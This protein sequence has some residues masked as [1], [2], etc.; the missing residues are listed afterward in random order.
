MTL[1]MLFGSRSKKRYLI[2]PLLPK[3]HALGPLSATL[4]KKQPRHPSDCHQLLDSLRV[5]ALN[6]P[7]TSWVGGV[8]STRS[9][10]NQSLLATIIQLKVCSELLACGSVRP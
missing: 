2:I 8:V 10:T 6:V 4:A 9:T 3:R 5:G 1:D 7:D